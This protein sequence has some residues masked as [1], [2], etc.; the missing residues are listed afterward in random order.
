MADTMTGG[1]F[2]GAKR[3]T[4]TVAD[5]DAYL[6]HCR[7]CQRISGNVSL[8]FKGMKQADVC[9]QTSPDYFESSPIARRGHCATC[10][11][12]LT[13]EFPDS[14]TMDLTVASS[15]EPAR[16]VPRHNY[17]VESW[18]EAWLDVRDLPAMRSDENPNV[19][20]RWMKACGKLPD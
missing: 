12:T 11:T 18:H 14:D 10:G 2:C 13:F 16:F 17:A 20:E 4:A 5:D 1:C 7:M 8:A 19:V 9:W 15:D 6:C 3:Y